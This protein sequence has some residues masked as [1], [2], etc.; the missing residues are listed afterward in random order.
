MAWDTS[1]LTWDPLD[2][3]CGDLDRCRKIH[4]FSVTDVSD[5][6]PVR[7]Q[8]RGANDDCQGRNALVHIARSTGSNFVIGLNWD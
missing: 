4:R 2:V 5:Y 7:G 8:L 1:G 6:E 3:L